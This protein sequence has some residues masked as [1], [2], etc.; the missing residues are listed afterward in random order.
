M[1]PNFDS[2]KFSTSRVRSAHGYDEEPVIDDGLT[3]WLPKFTEYHSRIILR[4]GVKWIIWSPNSRQDPFYPG[5][6]IHQRGIKEKAAW[7]TFVRTWWL[8]PPSVAFELRDEVIRADEKYVGVWLNGD[9]PEYGWWFLT[10]AAVPCFIINRMGRSVPA[11]PQYTTFTE[12]TPVVGL[13]SPYYEY[14]RIALASGGRYTTHKVGYPR[15]ESIARSG[16]DLVR[17]DLCWQLRMPHFSALPYTKGLEIREPSPQLDSPLCVLSPPPE[18]T[19]NESPRLPEKGRDKLI[20][21]P[22]VAPATTTKGTWV[23]FAE[24]D[25]QAGDPGFEDGQPVMLERGKNRKG[26]GDM[27][28]GQEVWYCR[29]FKRKLIFDELPRFEQEYAD[30]PEFGR[31]VPPWKFWH[32][33]DGKW[34]KRKE[35]KWM[36]RREQ[37]DVRRVG[38]IFKP[39][40]L[41]AE[42]VQV[43]EEGMQVDEA[44]K[45]VTRERTPASSDGRVSLG[46]SSR[47]S[48]PVSMAVDDEYGEALKFAE[49]TPLPEMDVDM[50][51]TAARNERE[52]EGV[53]KEKES[54]ALTDDN[55]REPTTCVRVMGSSLTF[56]V[57]DMVAWIGVGRMQR[58]RRM[59]R[60]VVR[61][62]AVDYVLETED[63][64]V[65]ALLVQEAR[66]EPRFRNN[67]R[68]LE[69]EEMCNATRGLDE[70]LLTLPV[71]RPA[72]PTLPRRPLSNSRE[73][74]PQ[75][76]ERRDNAHDRWNEVETNDLADSDLHLLLL[77]LRQSP[78]A[79]S[80]PLLWFQRR[81]PPLRRDPGRRRSLRGLCKHLPLLLFLSSLMKRVE[82]RLEERISL[83]DVEMEITPPPLES[84]PWTDA[85]IDFFIDQE[86]G[87]P[88]PEEMYE[89][90]G[91]FY[92]TDEE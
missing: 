90:Y 61:G 8:N 15:A 29:E 7:V 65:A 10:R 84:F 41:S 64:A 60:I 6:F 17:S 3:F 9:H 44:P 58:V 45:G 74:H 24:T 37:P 16:V 76:E 39:R 33:G 23:V 31:P 2:R 27:D 18:T 80:P 49:A 50:E 11:T 54:P 86:Q 19:T 78:D 70:Q 13:Q 53:I 26:K 46:P 21:P 57:A 91:D 20:V 25:L 59:W 5:A 81:N 85:E 47:S 52:D 48:S 88:P 72:A 77:H 67:A 42:P 32:P 35:S 79:N 36:Y 83:V 28:D 40:N 38:D 55:G 89:P 12:C 75:D 82:V 71:S 63:R 66:V 69:M 34:V 43:E 51:G 22:P 56:A 68:F 62:Y 87:A 30:D 1:S 73:R 4:A 14:D 92:D